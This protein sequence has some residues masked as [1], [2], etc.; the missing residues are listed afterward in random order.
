MQ[1]KKILIIDDDAELCE[2]LAELIRGEGYCVEAT[3]DSVRGN[4]LIKINSY[5][6]VI[7][8]FKM[9]NLTACEILK[10]V[11]TKNS[12]TKFV[13]ISGKPFIENLIEKENL[14]GLVETVISKPFDTEMLL[15]KIREIFAK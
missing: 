6:I 8:D 2:E 5:A 10:G 7:L 12:E 4:G 15:K 1:D 14:S 3:T 9:P 13:L 11:K